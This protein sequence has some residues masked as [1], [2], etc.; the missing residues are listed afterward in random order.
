MLK[1]TA[2]EPATGKQTEITVRNYSEVAQ[3]KGAVKARV[4]RAPG[5]DPV[6]DVVAAG[7]MEGSSGSM[8]SASSTKDSKRGAGTKKAKA[9]KKPKKK[10]A[11]KKK[12]A[13]KKPKKKAAKKPK[14]AAKK[15]AKKPKKAT[16]KT[17][18]KAAKKPSSKKK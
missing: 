3:S 6:E 9:P 11:P 15:A 8:P 18:K 1:V 5:A 4:D 17:V 13:A 16:K 14:K 12:K 10:A 2:M 7:A